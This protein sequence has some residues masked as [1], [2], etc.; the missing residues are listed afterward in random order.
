MLERKFDTA[1]RRDV[2]EVKKEKTY[3]ITALQIMTIVNVIVF[4]ILLF[5]TIVFDTNNLVSIMGITLG[6]IVSTALNYMIERD[7][8]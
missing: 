7:G 6:I 8:M 2:T 3:I 5:K 1:K 4:L